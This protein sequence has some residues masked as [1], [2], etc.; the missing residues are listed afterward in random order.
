MIMESKT[1]KLK[2]LPIVIFVAAIFG[3]ET[4]SAE[5][6]RSEEKLQTGYVAVVY[7]DNYQI[8]FVGLEN[9]HP[10]DIHKYRKIYKC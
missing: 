7:S 3:L 2:I 8:S 6:V 5:R 9:L 4:A 1:D 10:F